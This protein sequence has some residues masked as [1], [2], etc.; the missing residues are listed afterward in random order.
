MPYG[1]AA[2]L[3]LQITLC[4]QMRVCSTSGENAKYI[5]LVFAFDHNLAAFEVSWCHAHIPKLPLEFV[6][7]I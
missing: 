3:R 5:S 7:F 2:L 6:G 4:L 1:I